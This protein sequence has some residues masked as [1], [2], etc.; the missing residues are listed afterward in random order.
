MVA[1]FSVVLLLM[2]VFYDARLPMSV[3]SRPQATNQE[4]QSH[5][6]CPPCCPAMPAIAS[7][8]SA[9]GFSDFVSC[10]VRST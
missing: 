8:L 4:L 5:D 6:G 10:I 7:P 9:L 1:T 3:K 2:L